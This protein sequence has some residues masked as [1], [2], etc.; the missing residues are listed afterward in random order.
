MYEDLR[1]IELALHARVRAGL[2]STFGVEENEWWRKGISE[3]LR[4]KPVARR[5]E[6]EEPDSPEAPKSSS[7][8]SAFALR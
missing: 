5:E 8:Y 3:T 2:R 1:S 6:D 7:W 4:K